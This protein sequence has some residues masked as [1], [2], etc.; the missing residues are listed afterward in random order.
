MA[1]LAI[2]AAIAGSATVFGVSVA[3]AIDFGVAAIAS[4]G[5]AFA[6]DHR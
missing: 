4:V 6:G 1:F 5:V 2:G 3:G